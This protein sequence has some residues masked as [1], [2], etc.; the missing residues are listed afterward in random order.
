VLVAW[1]EEVNV[2][3]NLGP[4]ALRM[5]DRIVTPS[6]NRIEH[7]GGRV[8][9]EPKVMQV[10]VHLSAR[11]G[12]VSTKE[13]L[14]RSVWADAFVTDDVLKRAVSELRKAL[15]DDARAPR[16]IETIPRCG[17]RLLTPVVPVET[18][19]PETP[20]P[21]PALLAAVVRRLEAWLATYRLGF[22]LAPRRRHRI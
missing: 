7:A 14:L 2:G 21:L 5:G 11:P 16:F 4:P 18:P 22:I 17:Y 13:E 8:R 9:L 19:L 10:L 6:L 15:G 20:R 3:L 1:T 12:L